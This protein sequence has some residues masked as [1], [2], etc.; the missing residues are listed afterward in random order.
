MKVGLIAPPS[1]LNEIQPFSRF[2]LVLAHKVIY[3]IR[4]HNFYRDRS[5]AGDFI[6]LDN[7]AVEKRGRAMPMKNVA[8]AAMLIRP[9]VVVLPDVLF[10]AE[11][12]LDEIENALRS[13]HVRM[14]RRYMSNLK[15]AVVVQGLDVDEWL[16]C[17]KIL[18]GIPGID[19]LGIPM[20][21]S[22]LFGS[23]TECLREISGRVRKQCHLFGVRDSLEELCEQSRFPFVMGID[24]VKPVRLAVMGKG[25]DEWDTVLQTKDRGFLER[26]HS[27]VNLDLLHENCRRFVAMCEKY[28]GGVRQ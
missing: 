5:K 6:L 8:L 7:S 18:N 3:D 25:L 24:T 26:T 11:G 16:E 13:P 17:F 15:F 27:D 14:M 20:I 1:L 9:A 12:T 10:D 22:N 21:T 19:I 4:Y 23:R 28:E 2:H